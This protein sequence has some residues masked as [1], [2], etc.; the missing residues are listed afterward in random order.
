ME[1]SFPHVLKQKRL[2]TG[3]SQE[4]F[5]EKVGLS[6]RSISLLE[7]GKQQPTL[8]TLNKIAQAFNIKTS[9]L[10]QLIEK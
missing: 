8:P 9:E 10:L 6:M 7:T 1:T 5:A 3:L 4:K 2:A